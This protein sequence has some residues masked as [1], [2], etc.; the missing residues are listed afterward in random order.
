MKIL[1]IVL[2]LL[3]MAIGYT[4]ELGLWSSV[5]SLL[6]IFLFIGTIGPSINKEDTQVS[7]KI[8]KRIEE[9]KRN[10]LVKKNKITFVHVKALLGFIIML[11][12]SVYATSNYIISD[13]LLDDNSMMFMF[14]KE[15]RY[16]IHH[17]QNTSLIYL[18]LFFPLWFIE[19][20][21]MK[22]WVKTWSK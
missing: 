10:G 22:D 1:K 5:L 16:N 4:S 12:L 18:L 20:W 13:M 9:K 2:G 3:L 7:E 14:D 19:M 15:T 8:K 11:F 6:G 21:L 17:M